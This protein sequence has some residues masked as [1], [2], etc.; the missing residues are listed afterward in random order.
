MQAVC[1]QQE[2][3]GDSR[4]Q[5]PQFTA[6]EARR[7]QGTTALAVPGTD[8]GQRGPVTG[9][10]LGKALLSASIAA[11][12]GVGL[13]DLKHK[14]GDAHCSASFGASFLNAQPFLLDEATHTGW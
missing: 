5:V 4:N 9:K 7:A 2:A 1:T 14:P 6:N 3:A 12:E 11:Q 10:W 13:V 8:E